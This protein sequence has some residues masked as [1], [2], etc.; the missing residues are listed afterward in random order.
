LVR[1]TS[2]KAILLMCSDYAAM[3]KITLAFVASLLAPRTLLAQALPN[4]APFY[5][6]QANAAVND[7]ADR[8]VA[9]YGP[10]ALGATCQTEDLI[11]R[12]RATREVV[13]CKK[14][15]WKKP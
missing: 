14:G 3:N 8:N 7:L 10:V 13:W 9:R 15:H 5:V 6:A 2:M 12:S 1:S 11:S 4:D